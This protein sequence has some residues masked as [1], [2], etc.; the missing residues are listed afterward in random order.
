MGCRTAGVACLC[1]TISIGFFA[2]AGPAVAAT[3]L[4]TNLVAVTD[5]SGTLPF[6]DLMRQARPFCSQRQFG[7]FCEGEKMKFDAAGFPTSL[8][9]E[10]VARTI[11]VADTRYMPAGV[12][13]ASGREPAGSSS[14][15]RSPGGSRG[16]AH[17]ANFRIKPRRGATLELQIT[18]TDPTTTCAG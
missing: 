7:P 13:R 3:S 1:L 9:R 5:Y 15:R 10:H 17:S 8:P 14:R 18:A 2:L 6:S 11:L 12:Y 4:G 16:G